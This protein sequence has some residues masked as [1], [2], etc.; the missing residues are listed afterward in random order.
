MSGPMAEPVVTSQEHLRYRPRRHL[1]PAVVSQATPQVP[2]CS[3]CDHGKQAHA[4]YRRG[5]DCALCPCARY[6]RPAL[7]GRLLR[8]AP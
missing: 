3:T 8:L 5:T 1:R 4:H 2:L 6:R 7:L